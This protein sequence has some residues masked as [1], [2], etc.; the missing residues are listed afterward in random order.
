MTTPPEDRRRV[1]GVVL[2]AGES[3]RLGA[4]KQLAALDGESLVRRAV[5]ALTES[6]C[7]VV[8]IVVGA[9]ASVT[10]EAVAGLGAHVLTNEGWREGMAASI[11]TATTWAEAQGVNGLLIAVCDQPWLASEHV[12]AL[13]AAFRIGGRAVGSSYS[14]IVGVPAVFGRS[15]FPELLKLRGDRG[16]SALLRGAPAVAWSAGAID[17]DTERDLETARAGRSQPDLDR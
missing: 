8:G 2:A 16:A 9:H 1:A 12:N 5:R 3:R 4:P 11:R 15:E 6:E 14:G 17:V 7:A 13:L 10:V